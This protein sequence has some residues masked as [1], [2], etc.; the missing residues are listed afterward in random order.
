MDANDKEEDTVRF[1]QSGLADCHGVML[2]DLVLRRTSGGTNALFKW[3]G[4][5]W[6][7]QRNG[8]SRTIL[9]VTDA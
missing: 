7:T 9:P 6:K 8:P 3:F 2:A 1:P 5:L 4:G